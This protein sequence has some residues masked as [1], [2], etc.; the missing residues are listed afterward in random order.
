MLAR[1]V[2]EVSGG[3]VVA[4]VQGQRYGRVLLIYGVPRSEAYKVA[5]RA[6]NVVTFHDRMQ[7]VTR[8]GQ[9]TSIF[10]RATFDASGVVMGVGK[11]NEVIVS[12][13]R[14]GTV[15]YNEDGQ[16]C[17]LV[18][19]NVRVVKLS[20]FQRGARLAC[21]HSVSLGARYNFGRAIIHGLGFRL[22]VLTGR[23]ER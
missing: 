3:R 11:Y 18:G 7:N 15:T 13:F 20:Q 4:L 1:S 2:R 21:P 14:I 10:L 12:G 23:T 17:V 5:I 19:G 8:D 9:D 22:N 6:V 16:G